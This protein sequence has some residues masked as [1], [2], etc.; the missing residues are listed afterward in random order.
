MVDPVYKFHTYLIEK[1]IHG[2]YTFPLQGLLLTEE[3]CFQI[4]GIIRSKLFGLFKEI[5][6]YKETEY[7][8]YLEDQRELDILKPLKDEIDIKKDIT[9][10]L[11][12]SPDNLKQAFRNLEDRKRK[13]AKK[14]IEAEKKNYEKALLLELSKD[15]KEELIFRSV[16]G[17]LEEILNL[18]KLQIPQPYNFTTKELS[19]LEILI[20]AFNIMQ[21]NHYIA[22]EAGNHIF[23]SCI[24]GIALNFVKS[25]QVKIQNE[26]TIAPMLEFEKY[27]AGIERRVDCALFKQVLSKIICLT[28]MKTSLMDLQKCLMQNAD[29]MR[30]FCLCNDKKKIAGI[31]TNGIKWIFTSYKVMDFGQRDQFLVSKAVEILTDKDFGYYEMMESTYVRFF[32]SLISFI[33]E[34]MNSI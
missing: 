19:E 12:I 28:E 32:G 29:Q 15:L 27:S 31:A 5:C 30:A 11:A 34:N 17:D 13:K 33:T 21:K 4:C 20:K 10:Y 8:I 7:K 23:A 24:L 22:N 16:I 6:K 14:E 9:L 3:D 25:D 18:S 2:Q 1:N 26:Y